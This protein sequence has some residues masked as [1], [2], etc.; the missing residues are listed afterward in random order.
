MLQV[1]QLISA[2]S[3]AANIQAN[4]NPSVNVPVLSGAL[5]YPIPAIQNL[6]PAAPAPINNKRFVIIH[7]VEIPKEDIKTFQAY[8]RVVKYSYEI[9]NNISLD[10]LLF[11]YMFIDMNDKNGRRYY[12]NSDTTNYNVIAYI[13]FLEK[14]DSYVYNLEAQ[15]VLSA[16]PPRVHYKEMFDASLLQTVTDAPSKCLSV[17]N[18]LSSFFSSLAK[19]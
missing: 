2:S 19:K 10:N 7:T 1:P 14:F 6:N 4:Q 17:V 3:L 12:D 11:D 15:N 18:F 16:F 8:G 5:N 13:S 9:E